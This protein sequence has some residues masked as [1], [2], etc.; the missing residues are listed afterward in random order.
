MR[1]FPPPMQG[2]AFPVAY[3]YQGGN[4]GYVWNLPQWAPTT[5]MA[6]FVPGLHGQMQYAGQ[7][8]PDS[9]APAGSQVCP[10]FIVCS[11]PGSRRPTAPRRPAARREGWDVLQNVVSHPV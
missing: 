4:Y 2:Q 10:L 11:K 8:A 3:Q 7:Q 9:A 1:A 5:S 6:L